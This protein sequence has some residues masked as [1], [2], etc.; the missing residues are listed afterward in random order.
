MCIGKNLALMELRIV[1]ALLVSR[2]EIMFA[3]G[4]DGTALF[5]DMKDAF[6]AAPGDL[7]LIFQRRGGE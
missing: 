2:Y 5:R 1:T 3:P 6:T 7:R 4:E